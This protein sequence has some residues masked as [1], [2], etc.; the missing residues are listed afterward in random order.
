MKSIKTQPD[1]TTTNTPSEK[2]SWKN[3]TVTVLDTTSTLGKDTASME[4]GTN[5]GPS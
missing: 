5:T 3:P 2:K 4:A 1:E